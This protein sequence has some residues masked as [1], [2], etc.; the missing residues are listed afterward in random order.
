MSF[1]SHMI[2]ILSQASDPI[3][4]QVN[5][6]KAYVDSFAGTIDDESYLQQVYEIEFDNG[7]FGNLRHMVDKRT[8]Y[9]TSGSDVSHWF[10]ITPNE[11]TA[12]QSA[13]SRPNIS[14]EA[15]EFRSSEYFSLGT[16]SHMAFLNACTLEVWVSFFN[17]SR[18]LFGVYGAGD[19]QDTSNGSRCIGVDSDTS[20]GPDHFFYISNGSANS[21]PGRVNTGFSANQWIH[22]VGTYDGTNGSAACKFYV[23]GSLSQQLSG[24]TSPLQNRAWYIGTSGRMTTMDGRLARCSAWDKVLAPSEITELY[25]FQSSYLS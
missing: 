6:H 9:L 7:R 5:R 17:N 20:N 23:N 18:S 3:T 16:P 14:S 12:N 10:D 15:L 1:A 2:G 4:F 21:Q 19:I 11:L 13:G 8:G 22:L 24:I 25:N